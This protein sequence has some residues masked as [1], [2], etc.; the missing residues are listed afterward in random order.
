MKCSPWPACEPPNTPTQEQPSLLLILSPKRERGVTREGGAQVGC[1]LGTA[2]AAA[3]QGMTNSSFQ[4][5]HI[6][7]WGKG[8]KRGGRETES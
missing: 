6:L 3:P 8:S 2:A 5:E 7:A 4:G 1:W